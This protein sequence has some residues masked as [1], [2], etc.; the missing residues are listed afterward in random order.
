MEK[1]FTKPYE[2]GWDA[3]PASNSW[4]TPEI[5]DNYD[6]AIDEIDNRVIGQSEDLTQFIDDGFLPKE[7]ING[8]LTL[9][10]NY[11]TTTNLQRAIIDYTVRANTEYV[12]KADN[13]NSV[14]KAFLLTKTSASAQTYIS[15]MQDPL[16]EEFVFTTQ[17][18][19]NDVTICFISNNANITK[20][21]VETCNVTLEEYVPSNIVLKENLTQLNTLAK[22][23][24][25]TGITYLNS[26]LANLLSF[27]NVSITTNGGW[28]TVGTL[29]TE[30]KKP[31]YV[32]VDILMVSTSPYILKA[33]VLD[34]GT[35]RVQT[36]GIASGTNVTLNGIITYLA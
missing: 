33:Q 31:S 11:D 6:N 36:Q 29:T 22:K 7:K 35:V 10:K 9:G 32:V 1:A 19:A 25:A 26:G 4:V 23:T 34:T 28:V 13:F 12:V 2:N 24:L 5:M 14:K 3:K 17:A 20:A 18:N 15:I 27:D 8:I 21:E 30:Y 16:T